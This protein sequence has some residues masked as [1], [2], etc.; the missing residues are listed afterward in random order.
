MALHGAM[1]EHAPD[2]LLADKGYDADAICADPTKW[3]IEAD[4][5][6]RPNGRVEIEH[7][8]ALYRQRTRIER[9]FGQLKVNGASAT[10]YDQLANCFLGTVHI[11]AAKYALKSVHA[12]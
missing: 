1:P 4:I 6:D 2:A 10:R 8:R 7:E 3:N 11:A 5:P 12:A 9:M